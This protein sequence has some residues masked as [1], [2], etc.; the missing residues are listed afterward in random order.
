MPDL[1]R[2]WANPETDPIA[3]RVNA[4]I[5]NGLTGALTEFMPLS[6]RA[7]VADAIHASLRDGGVTFGVVDGLAR[8]R[9][10]SF[11]ASVEAGMALNLLPCGCPRGV[12]EDI[13]GHNPATCT[14]WERNHA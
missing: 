2:P 9:E 1:G 4:L 5:F 11:L 10:A 8:L 12:G 3:R 6:E 14:A 13:R 7:R